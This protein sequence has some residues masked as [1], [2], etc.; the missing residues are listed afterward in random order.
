MATKAQFLKRCYVLGVDVEDDGGAIR[1]C[2]PH[3]RKLKMTDTH[4]SALFPYAMGQWKKADLYSMLMED[5]LAEGLILCEDED[6]DYCK[7]WEG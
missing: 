7:S 1:V 2:C 6:C 4:E 3:G 5:Y